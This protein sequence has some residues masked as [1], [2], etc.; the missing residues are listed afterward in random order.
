MAVRI[1]IPDDS[2]AVISG[3][4][5]LDRIRAAGETVVYTSPP[6]SEDDLIG[7]LDR[8]HTAIN[9]RGSSKFTDRMWVRLFGQIG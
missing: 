3:T 2:P 6:A 9:I 8:A 7:R 4:P 1:V 5:A